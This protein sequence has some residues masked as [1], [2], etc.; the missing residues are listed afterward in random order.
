MDVVVDAVL[1]G[2]NWTMLLLLFG[3]LILLFALTALVTPRKH[4]GWRK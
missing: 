1:T 4:G 2:N 3:D